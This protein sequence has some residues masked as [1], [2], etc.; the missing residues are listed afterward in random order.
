MEGLNPPTERYTS[1]NRSVHNHLENFEQ[2][3]LSP[4]VQ[5]TLTQTIRLPV[6]MSFGASS[7]CFGSQYSCSPHERT[8]KVLKQTVHLSISSLRLYF[9]GMPSLSP[10][11][12]L[13]SF[14]R[15]GYACRLPNSSRK[16]T[17][18]TIGPASSFN[19]RGRP[20]YLELLS[21]GLSIDNGHGCRVG[22]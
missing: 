1:R 7:R 4:L 16:V 9:L 3:S 11:P 22:F 10:S 2:Q 17:S 21:N 8:S 15:R 12:I 13:F 18:S 14:Y 20:W 6:P 5:V 19:I